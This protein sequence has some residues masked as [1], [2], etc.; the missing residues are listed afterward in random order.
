VQFIL[1]TFTVSGHPKKTKH[2]LTKA[3]ESQTWDFLLAYGF[4][5]SE[6]GAE[7]YGPA[8]HTVHNTRHVQYN[9]TIHIAT[10]ML[11]KVVFDKATFN[12]MNI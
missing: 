5:S 10:N 6:R 1:E 11:S 9:N 7:T 4:L 3:V 8:V 12:K 2:I